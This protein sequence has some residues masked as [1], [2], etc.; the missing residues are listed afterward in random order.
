MKESIFL[1]D[2]HRL[3]ALYVPSGKTKRKINKLHPLLE[4]VTTLTHTRNG[5]AFLKLHLTCFFI[6]RNKFILC[7]SSDEIK[8]N[9][10]F[11]FNNAATA[12]YYNNKYYTQ[13][14]SL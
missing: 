6:F 8:G 12:S 14:S 4:D 10:S 1:M 3:S 9:L 11:Y 7:G 13:T 2:A 5:K